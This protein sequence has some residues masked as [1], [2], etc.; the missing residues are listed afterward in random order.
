[1]KTYDGDFGS[2][3]LS[4]GTTVSKDSPRVETYGVI[5]ELN[6]FL[7]FAAAHSNDKKVKDTIRIVQ[8]NLFTLGADL[9]SRKKGD[10]AKSIITKDHV[11]EIE[12]IIDDFQKELPK[13][14]KF[15]LPGGTVSSSALH[16]ARSVCR[17]AERRL[18]ALQ[19]KESINET[20]IVYVN[21]LSD[22]LFVLARYA[23]IKEGKEEFWE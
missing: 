2:T 19:R 13:I 16:V 11:E 9:A 23:N 12:H 10:K 4:D 14:T 8:K 20:I 15:I 21:R 1:M 5:D 22:L 6:S 3:K 7:G 17:R 18:V